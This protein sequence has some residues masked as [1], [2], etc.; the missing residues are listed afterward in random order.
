MGLWEVPDAQLGL[1]Y[2]WKWRK[3]E[4]CLILCTIGILG[5]CEELNNFLKCMPQIAD[6]MIEW[7][8][9]FQSED[10]CR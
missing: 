2:M 1:I 9:C 4:D 5:N 3:K 7:L 10:E 6:K 8:V